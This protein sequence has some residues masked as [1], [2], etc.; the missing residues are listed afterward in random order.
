MSFWTE[1]RPQLELLGIVVA[2]VA[3]WTAFGACVAAVWP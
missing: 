3:F 1:H 2:V